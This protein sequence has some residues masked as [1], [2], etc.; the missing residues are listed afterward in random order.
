MTTTTTTTTVTT[1]TITTTTS[2]TKHNQLDTKDNNTIKR[3]KITPLSGGMFNCTVDYS[4]DAKFLHASDLTRNE[5]WSNMSSRTQNL[6]LMYRQSIDK[7]KLDPS[8][9]FETYKKS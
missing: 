8:S 1:V 2:D 7:K 4:D 3:V 9:Q 5:Y 6:L